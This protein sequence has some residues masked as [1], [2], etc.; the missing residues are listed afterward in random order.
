[1][2]EPSRKQPSLPSGFGRVF[3]FVITTAVFF[4]SVGILWY[5]ATMADVT[6]EINGESKQVRTHAN[7]VG[8]LMNEL[9]I[10]VEE[11]D[12]L[13]RGLTASI[14]AGMNLTYKRA[15]KVTVVMDDQ[16][17]IY[18]T[19]SETVGEFLKEKNIEVSEYDVMVPDVET[20]VTNDL[21]IL[22][23]KARQV[24][25]RD[26]REEQEIWT[27]S[28]RVEDLL[29]DQR[30][31]LN[32]LD[33]IEPSLNHPLKDGLT[34]TITRVEKKQ[35][36]VEEPL[37]FT[38]ITRYDHSMSKG[39]IKVLQKGKKGIVEKHY[40]VTYKN[41]K[42]VNRELVKKVTKQAVQDKI[43]VVGTK[44]V[45]TVSCQGKGEVVKELTMKATAY[46]AYCNGCSGVTAT[47]I[48]LRANPN[49]KVVAVDPDVIPLGSTVWVE[50]YGCAI[51]GDIGSAIQ[52]NK[53]DLFYPLKSQASS[54]GIKTVRVKVYKK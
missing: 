28:K 33:E 40:E 45:K 35:D 51:A 52:G 37:D 41:G 7:T 26:G 30:I 47:N 29:R 53:I 8:E 44:P 5:E 25:V 20:L 11:N 6:I 13:S 27:T 22:I 42:E 31:I 43:V 17:E 10:S 50:G 54:Y 19:T 49:L 36:V 12:Y 38:T 1:M 2:I 46:T 48:D 9:N 34:I 4:V 3:L 32:D 24:T 16:E 18:F 15:K 23:Q 39:Q 21:S 14:Q